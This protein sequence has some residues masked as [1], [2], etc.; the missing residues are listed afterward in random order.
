MNE[1]F[2]YWISIIG[3]ICSISGI[4]IITVVKFLDPMKKDYTF[5]IIFILLFIICLSS[6]IYLS[7]LVYSKNK[8]LQGQTIYRSNRH[9]MSQEFAA[10]SLRSI[11]I[12]SGDLTW[13]EKD[14]NIYSKLIREKN[15]VV[16]ILTHIEDLSVIKAA[17]EFGIQFKKYPGNLIAPLTA[18]IFDG[19]DEYE[20]RAL[21]VKKTSLKPSHSG[22]DYRYKFKK[23]YGRNDGVAIKGLQLLFDEY[24]KNGIDL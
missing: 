7:C 2:L 3:S 1:K 9:K 5:S 14:L 24:F 11:D 19:N 17:K 23:Y 10:S 20:S 6:I 8:E 12:F 16:R 18:S 21:I 15:V 13:L 4:S 22:T